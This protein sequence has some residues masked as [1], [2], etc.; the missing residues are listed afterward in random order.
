M[1]LRGEF[2]VKSL[3]EISNIEHRSEAELHITYSYQLMKQQIPHVGF[4]F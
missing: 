1:P 2:E 4:C 3:N